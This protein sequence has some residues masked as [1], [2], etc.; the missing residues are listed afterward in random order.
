M[1]IEELRELEP[2]TWHDEVRFH[3]LT[4]CRT[5]T[6]VSGGYFGVVRWESCVVEGRYRYQWDVCPLEDVVMGPPPVLSSGGSNKLEYAKR[7]VVRHLAAISGTSKRKDMSERRKLYLMGL[8]HGSVA[9]A[10]V[11]DTTEFR[12]RIAFHL[13]NV[14]LPLSEW[15]EVEDTPYLKTMADVRDLLRTDG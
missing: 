2:D 5:Y 14:G 12:Q 3:G 13:R 6:L 4:E 1:D 15:E 7:A 8:E 11:R 9:W 10:G